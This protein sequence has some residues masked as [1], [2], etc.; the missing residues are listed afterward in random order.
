MRAYLDHDDGTSVVLDFV[1]G[2]N[3]KMPCCSAADL[4]LMLSNC[5]LHWVASPGSYTRL[6]V[7]SSSLL[8]CDVDNDDAS[9][10]W[11]NLRNLRQPLGSGSSE[12]FCCMCFQKISMDVAE[13]GL[14]SARSR[15][16]IVVLRFINGLSSTFRFNRHCSDEISPIASVTAVSSGDTHSSSPCWNCAT[17]AQFVSCLTSSE[18]RKWLVE[19]PGSPAPSKSDFSSSVHGDGNSFFVMLFMMLSSFE[20]SIPS[21]RVAISDDPTT[22]EINYKLNQW[23]RYVHWTSHES[24]LNVNFTLTCYFYLSKIMYVIKI[25]LS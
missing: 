6:S 25:P 14:S 21:T 11:D 10:R 2:P 22:V 13:S 20:F 9:L 7:S 1:L 16:G 3:L 24:W 18:R 17:F 15:L 12:F 19:A 8:R 5:A 4:K 23:N